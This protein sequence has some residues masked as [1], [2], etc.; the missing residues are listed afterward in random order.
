MP[1]AESRAEIPAPRPA[2]MKRYNRYKCYKAGFTERF[3]LLKVLRVAVCSASRRRI[4]RRDAGT[5]RRVEVSGFVAPNNAASDAK[6]PRANSEAGKE[7]REFGGSQ[8]RAR[9]GLRK[10]QERINDLF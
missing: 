9:L 10:G 3:S 4:R 1:G 5:V 8:G 7:A 6:V 2:G